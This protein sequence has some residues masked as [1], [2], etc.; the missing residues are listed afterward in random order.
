MHDTHSNT[1]P[2]VSKSTNAKLERLRHLLRY[3]NAMSEHQWQREEEAERERERK[4]LCVC[5][6]ASDSDLI[7]N[8]LCCLMTAICAYS[9]TEN[10][11][12]KYCR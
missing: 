2:F 1:V 11:G 4:R 8:G 3:R 12:G 9:R 10:N 6:G 7:R 5:E